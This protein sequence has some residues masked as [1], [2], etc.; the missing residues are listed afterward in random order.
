VF[1]VIIAGGL[2]IGVRGMLRGWELQ[3]RLACAEQMKRIGAA[4]KIYGDQPRRDLSELVSLGAVHSQDLICPA[5]HQSNYSAAS[6]NGELLLIE[7]LSNH[8]DGANVL[9]KDGRVSF[10]PDMEYA[11]LLDR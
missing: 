7:P 2:L 6:Q 9:F 5:G 4:L 8:A 1:V 11:Q 10:V 3:R